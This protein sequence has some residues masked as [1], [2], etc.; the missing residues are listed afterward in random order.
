[1]DRFAFDSSDDEGGM[2]RAF[3]SGIVDLVSGENRAS[4]AAYLRAHGKIMRF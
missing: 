3:K 4:F 1:M 2:F